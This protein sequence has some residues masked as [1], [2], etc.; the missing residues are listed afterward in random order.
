MGELARAMKKE[1]LQIC[2]QRPLQDSQRKE[3]YTIYKEE[4]LW[5]ICPDIYNKTATI[6]ARPSAF[7]IS[8][9]FATVG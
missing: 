1:V 8:R 6:Q 7:A 3:V 5:N 9:L 2:K 4:R